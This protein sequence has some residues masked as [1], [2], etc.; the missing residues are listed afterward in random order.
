MRNTH[1]SSDS[2]S[3]R[4]QDAKLEKV[5]TQEEIDLIDEQY[6][7]RE[8]RYKKLVEEP[9]NGFLD[10]YRK[11]LISTDIHV[12]TEAIVF[13]QNTGKWCIIAQKDQEKKK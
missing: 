6:K 11:N 9:A 13:D 5:Y 3:N 4:P 10:Q 8:Q 1:V 7:E 12:E 2:V